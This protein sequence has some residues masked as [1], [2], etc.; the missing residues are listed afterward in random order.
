[1]QG[2]LK[3]LNFLWIFIFCSME[4]NRYFDRNNA[5]ALNEAFLSE[6]NNCDMHCTGCE[7]VRY[8]LLTLRPSHLRYFDR[9]R[10]FIKIGSALVWKLLHQSQQ[11]VD[12]VTSATLS[13]RVQNFVVI[14]RVHFKAEHCKN[15]VEFRIRSK[16]CLWDERQYW[17][18]Y[19]DTK[20]EVI[21]A[22]SLTR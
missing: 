19:Q 20:I 4:V 10:N 15:L 6:L 11:N 5:K 9:M 2:G 12:H 1:M 7:E 18:L 8:G 3:E 13:W 22:S 17:V 14:G 21:L 16:Y